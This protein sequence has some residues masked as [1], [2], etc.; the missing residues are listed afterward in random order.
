M[1]NAGGGE[2][3]LRS[4]TRVSETLRLSSLLEFGTRDVV[5]CATNLT[6]LFTLLALFLCSEII[7]PLRIFRDNSL[8]S[9]EHD[10][11]ELRTTEN[12]I[13]TSF[14]QINRTDNDQ[15]SYTFMLPDEP[16]F[17]SL[18]ETFRL[19]TVTF[20]FLTPRRFKIAGTDRDHLGQR[21]LKNER[22]GD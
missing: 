1:V 8:L 7:S 14:H 17:Y 21:T 22:R 4:Q 20:I 5:N 16:E 6:N 2:S 13:S 9:R 11:L 12:L 15:I 10:I 18:L 19:K 3:N